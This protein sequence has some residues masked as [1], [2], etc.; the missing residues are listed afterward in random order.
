MSFSSLLFALAVVVAWPFMLFGLLAGSAWLE[1]YTLDPEAVVPRR[2]HR[3]AG[4]PAD[5]IEAMVAEETAQVVAAYWQ[6]TG[7]PAQELRPTAAAPDRVG[8][9]AAA[10][11]GP[12]AHQSERS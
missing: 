9:T 3:M 12:T 5:V 6:A 4:L 10:A 1:R 11:W 8:F 2:L 7:R